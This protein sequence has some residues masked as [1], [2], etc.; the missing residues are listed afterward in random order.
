MNESNNHGVYGKKNGRKIAPENH[1]II[2]KSQWYPQQHPATSQVPYLLYPLSISGEEN[3]KI[4]EIWNAGMYQGKDFVMP[5]I[6]QIPGKRKLAQ[7]LACALKASCATY[8]QHWEGMYFDWTLNDEMERIFSNFTV[9]PGGERYVKNAFATAVLI[10]TGYKGVFMDLLVWRRRPLPPSMMSLEHLDMGT[11]E[12]NLRNAICAVLGGEYGVNIIRQSFSQELTA[13]E[14]KDGYAELKN[15]VTIPGMNLQGK[16]ATVMQ[17]GLKKPNDR[18]VFERRH[19]DLAG[20]KLIERKSERR[21]VDFSLDV[22]DSVMVNFFTAMNQQLNEVAV[23]PFVKLITIDGRTPEGK[24]KLD[25]IRYK[26]QTGIDRVPSEI[27]EA[28]VDN[29]RDGITKLDFN[30]YSNLAHLTAELGKKVLKPRDDSQRMVFI[31][32][33]I[34]K[35]R[36]SRIPIDVVEHA[37]GAAIQAGLN[38]IHLDGTTD[39]PEDDDLKYGAFCL[40]GPLHSA[41]VLDTDEQTARGWGHGF[42]DILAP[43]LPHTNKMVALVAISAKREQDAIIAEKQAMDQR[44][45]VNDIF[46]YKTWNHPKGKKLDVPNWISYSH[47]LNVL[48][49]PGNDLLLKEDDIPDQMPANHPITLKYLRNYG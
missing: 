16:I 38:S 3:R 28:Y 25:G 1:N 47:I 14:N 11:F 49:I 8:S 43:E 24:E 15:L 6:G 33:D 36:R 9:M 48:Q 41:E 35:Q 42:W 44:K 32:I 19:M 37:I 45:S 17:I 20:A 34:E 7:V 13:S 21:N 18:V 31:Y 5:E 4:R 27:I 39:I 26:I 22:P 23:D 40:T 30:K 2:H 46:W 29:M 10:N 12:C